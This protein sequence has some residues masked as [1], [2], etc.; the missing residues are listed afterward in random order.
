MVKNAIWAQG[1][2]CD[3]RKLVS[4]TFQINCWPLLGGFLDVPVGYEAVLTGPQGTVWVLGEGL[5]SLRA[6]P[7]GPYAA[8]FVNTCGHSLRLPAV[9]ALTQDGWQASLQVSLQ[10]RVRR[11]ARAVRFYD[12]LEVLHE[13][14]ISAITYVIQSTP[15]D[16]LIGTDNGAG[17]GH[18]SVAGQIHRRLQATLRETG[19]GLEVVNV[20]DAQAQGDERRLEVKRQ[21]Q[22]NETQIAADRTVLSQK[23]ELEREQQGLAL[24]QAETKRKQAEEEQKVRLEKAR[25]EIE[26]NRLVREV[27]EWE[28]HLEMVPGQSQQRH[29]QILE[30]I[31]TYG[32]ILGKVAELNN[33]EGIG[34]SSR[35]RPE[36]WGL[37]HLETVLLQSLA[38]LQALLTQD[39]L[40][41]AGNTDALPTPEAPLLTR[42]TSDIDRL[43]TIEGWTGT[44]IESC[45][46]GSVCL[47]IYF[48]GKIVEVICDPSFPA[49][50]PQVAV[51]TNGRKKVH[52]LLPKWEPMPLKEVVL[53]AI[54]PDSDAD[55]NQDAT[56]GAPAA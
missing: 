31:K 49:T 2:K 39:P 11:P 29:E 26:V 3:D 9:P 55:S 18:R 50:R 30:A 52:S 5:Q 19:T 38:S 15:H 13:A 21:S 45:A 33:L 1:P 8:R 43:K 7:W 40:G 41:P 25:I 24:L 22:V 56:S 36:E 51:A 44:H 27:R 28:V 48:K 53:E 4:P 47:E 34:V 20:F 6:L 37:N 42:L 17:R 16:Q 10:F 46:D 32:Q 12:P 54:H 35:R 14:G 23:I